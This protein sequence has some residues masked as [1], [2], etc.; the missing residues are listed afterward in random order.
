MGDTIMA[1]K[2]KYRKLKRL[3]IVLLLFIAAF[4]VYVEVANRNTKNMTYRQKVLKAVYPAFMWI[5]KLTGSNTKK[6]A[7]EGKT[8]VIPFYSLQ[9]LLNNGDILDFASLQGKKVLLVNTASDCGYTNQYNDL[10]AL[11]E[12]YKDKLVVLGFPANDFKEQEKGTDAEIAKFCK[13][14]FGISFPLMKKTV[15]IK[16]AEQNPVFQWLTDSA[17]NGWN[18]KFPSWNFSKYLVNEKGILTNYFGPSVSP[19]S[20]E[21]KQAIVQ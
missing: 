4:A 10:Q 12:R 17:K 1:A 13:A 14:N 19:M 18:N 8:P 15:V 21:V 9:A 6:L 2:T 11:A 7:N 3:L 5:N 16:S 20:E